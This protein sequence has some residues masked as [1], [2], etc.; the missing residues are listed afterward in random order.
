MP[1]LYLVEQAAVVHRDG[2]RLIVRRGGETLLSVPIFKVDGVFVFGHV[3]VTT[4][5]VELILAHGVDLAYFS[6]NGRLKGRLVGPVSRNV[7]LRVQQFRKAQD[8]A[9]CLEVARAVV[10]AKVWNARQVL[11]RHAR[12][13]RVREAVDRLAEL[14]RAVREANSVDALRGLEGVAAGVYFRVWTAIVHREW[15]FR[16]RQK[17]PPRDPINALLSLG[18][19]LL[20]NEMIGRVTAHGFD[21][22]VGFYHSLRYGRPSLALDLVEEFRQPVVDRLVLALVNRG[23]VAPSDFEPTQEGGIALKPEA[24]RR[25]LT[26]Y[27]RYMRRPVFFRRPPEGVGKDRQVSY[28]EL[29]DIQVR[30]FAHSVYEGTAYTPFRMEG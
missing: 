18:Y 11:R 8:P 3:Q 6:L 28:R 27:D 20:T 4:Q 25:F 16:G 22:Y 2:D 26:A 13:A 14:Y 12:D 9:F 7:F 17:R 24:L 1:L 15:G 29:L 5:A 10:A 21:P 30:H 19:T 23:V